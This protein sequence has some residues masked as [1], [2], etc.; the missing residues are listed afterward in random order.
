[1]ADPDSRRPIASRDTGWARKL[2]VWLAERN[3]TPNGI[4][5]ASMLAAAAACF[6]FYMAGSASGSTRIGLLLAAALCC[7]LR[8]ICNLLDG[9]VAVEAGKGAR[10]GPFWNEFPDRVSDILIFVGIGY[11]VDAPILGWT[12]A[13]FSVLTAYTRELGRA[14]GLEADFSGPMAKP[15]RMALVTAAAAISIF[16]GFWSWPNSA[17]TAALWA[18]SL[19]ALFTSL[20]RARRMVRALNDQD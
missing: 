6:A 20:R 2:T 17:L 14:S 13:A 3:V 11:G 7:Q 19:G 5:Q 9:M 12:A 16:D 4:S 15:Q 10:D 18:V 1:M 8:L